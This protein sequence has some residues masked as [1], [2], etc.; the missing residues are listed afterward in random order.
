MKDHSFKFSKVPDILIVDD[1][2]A[3]LKILESILTS[4]GYKVRPVTNGRM[5]LQ[6]AKKEKPDLILLD[7]MMPEMNGF[8]VCRRLKENP[9]FIDIPVIFISA[10]NDTN[11]IVKALN[12]GGVDYITKPFQAEEVIVRVK[13]HLKL[14]L[15]KK[16][17]LDQGLEL[18][19]IN[20]EKDKFFSIIAHDLRS[21]ICGLLGLTQLLVD[22]LPYL[23]IEQVQPIAQGLR[24]TTSKVFDLLEDLLEWAKIQRGIIPF[25]PQFEKL[26]PIAVESLTMLQ[27]SANVKEIEIENIIPDELNVFT[28]RNILLTIIRNLIS[29]A[30]KFTNQGGKIT[31]SAHMASNKMVEIS[32]QD[33][34]IGMSSEL[35]EDLFRIDVN[36]GRRGTSGEVGTGLGLIICKESVE[37]NGGELYLESIVGKGSIFRFTVPI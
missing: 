25:N 10:L 15:Q 14:Y 24:N 1:V 12:H 23:T 3:N 20:A 4:E 7:I 17:L 11:D 9:D 8:E 6:V 19:K 36:S 27:E 33:S 35:I 2:P 16:E 26:L 29:N 30:V 34:G 18:Q 32:I 5:A 21:P 22:E 31:L 37:K 28:D 13:T